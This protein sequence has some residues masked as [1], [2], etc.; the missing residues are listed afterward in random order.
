MPVAASVFL[1]GDVWGGNMLW[2][3]DRCVALI[4]WKLDPQNAVDA[5]TW[6]L[7]KLEVGGETSRWST[8]GRSRPTTRADVTKTS[9][10]TATAIGATTASHHCRV[11]HTSTATA[12]W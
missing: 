12:I 2:E 1:H 6:P 4:D 5:P 9:A 8:S 3:G 7:G 10:W 11:R